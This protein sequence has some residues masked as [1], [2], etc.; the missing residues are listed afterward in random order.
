MMQ[1]RPTYIII[2]HKKTKEGWIGKVHPV[3]EEL[4]KEIRD[5]RAR[6]GREL[7]LAEAEGEHYAMAK[8]PELQTTFDKLPSVVELKKYYNE[9]LK[10]SQHL[11]DLLDDAGRNSLLRLNSKK[12]KLI[13]DMTHTKIDGRAFEMLQS[14][15]KETAVMEKIVAMFVGDRINTTEDRSVCHTALRM[16]SDEHLIVNG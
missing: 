4:N 14:V 1:S 11:K 16:E 12:L 5:V 13:L 6:L 15:A 7:D 9:N 10:N 3:E 8:V 2:E